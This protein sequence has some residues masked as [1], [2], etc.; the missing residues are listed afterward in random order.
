MHFMQ[1]TTV[2]SSNSVLIVDDDIDA[3]DEMRD[4]LQDHGLKV[5]TANDVG[6]ALTLAK[7]HRPEFILMDYLLRECTGA[8]AVS[9]VLKFLPGVQVI[10]MS[11]FDDL[12][13]RVT[14]VDSNVIAILK[15]PLSINS[16][17]RFIS[18]KLEHK[19]EQSKINST[20]VEYKGVDI[21]TAISEDESSQL[22]MSEFRPKVLIVEDEREIAEEIVELLGFDGLLECE[23]ASD[24]NQAMDI[25][26][27]NDDIVIIITDLQMPGLDGLQMMQKLKTKYDSKRDFATIVITGHGGTKEA[28]NALQLGAI[29]FINKPISTEQLLHAVGRASETLQLKKREIESR[30][31]L[32]HKVEERTQEVNMLSEDLLRSSRILQS[33]NLKL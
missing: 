17:I 13:C 6:V 11:A 16:I 32:E 2:M 8:E 28:I 18:N 20:F 30:K 15:K 14:S 31:Y 19:K 5:Y 21:I 9:E 4:A 22:D 24:G 27:A 3:L 23:I 33:I 7:K 29:D 26:E 1:L 25:I 12:A 10:M